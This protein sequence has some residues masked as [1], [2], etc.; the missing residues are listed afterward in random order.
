MQCPEQEFTVKS[1]LMQPGKVDENELE[2]F[3]NIFKGM[4]IHH[5]YLTNGTEEEGNVV[6]KLNSR[7]SFGLVSGY[8]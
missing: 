4:K 6:F 1:F 8:I 3:L 2:E 5:E 7:N